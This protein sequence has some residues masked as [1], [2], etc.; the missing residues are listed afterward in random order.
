M[1]F[2]EKD[3][4]IKITDVE[5]LKSKLAKTLDRIKATEPQFKNPVFN[6]HFARSNKDMNILSNLPI[7]EKIKAPIINSKFLK[8]IRLG[9]A[10][11]MI[12]PLIYCLAQ[13]VFG[14]DSYKPYF[15]SLVLDIIRIILHWKVEFYD[16]RE[17]DELR[18]RKKD[19]IINYL[20]RNPFYS[21][22]LKSKIIIPVLNKIFPKSEFIKKMIIYIIE[23]RSSISLL[24]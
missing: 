11:H 5:K 15:I 16:P 14:I 21:H 6:D 18:L 3:P 9:E 22:I 7:P 8:R 2:K 1:F 19:I 20:L 23:I 4:T 10:I 17:I 24:M 13:I 12:R